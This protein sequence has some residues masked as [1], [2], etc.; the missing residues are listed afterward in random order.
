[1]KRPSIELDIFEWPLA[2]E[3]IRHPY[4][5]PISP[6]SKFGFLDE[7]ARS[8]ALPF[9][10]AANAENLHQA[11][12]CLENNAAD[13]LIIR[14]YEVQCELIKTKCVAILAFMPTENALVLTFR[15]INGVVQAMLDP[16]NMMA[17]S[18]KDFEPV[19]GKV[20]SSFY[21]MFFDLWKEGL[22]ADLR[23]ELCE[24]HTNAEIWI[25]GHSLG[26]SLAAL[27]AAWVAKSGMTT[28]EQIR[29]ISFGQP[30][31]GNLEFARHFD[32][33][34]PHKYRVVHSEDIIPRLPPK[35]LLND[36]HS[37]FHHRY[38]V[39]YN[40]DMTT[41]SA[42]ELC[43]SAD[44]IQCSGTLEPALKSPLPFG[45]QQTDPLGSYM[46]HLSYYNVS[47]IAWHRSGCAS[48]G[49]LKI[50]PKN[51]PGIPD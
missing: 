1:M 25:F 6:P 26:G 7:F 18:L 5:C 49:H 19:G 10:A 44:G 29:F 39:W 34:L 36:E 8:R 41:G 4:N 22:D 43:E 11:Q 28:V 42:Y 24:E 33:L 20:I 45:Q 14:R 46:A 12:I 31:T 9:I 35:L 3:R 32:S 38:E 37:L 48:K 40:N 15:A 30:R 51:L 16:L 23:H 47:L 21:D 17:N 27:A 13:A 2:H 50:R